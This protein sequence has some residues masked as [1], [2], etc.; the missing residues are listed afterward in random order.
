VLA[1]KEQVPKALLPVFLVNK[2][3]IITTIVI[4]ITKMWKILVP[5]IFTLR[6]YRTFKIK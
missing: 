6:D 5:T 2:E 4:K 3:N 1:L